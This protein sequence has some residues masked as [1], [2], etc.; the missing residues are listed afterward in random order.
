L[1]GTSGKRIERAA[2]YVS[3]DGN[4][5]WSG[6]R[7]GPNRARKDGPFATLK[8]AR[9]EIRAMG[10]LPEGGVTVYLLGGTHIM[11]ASLELTKED[12]GTKQAPILYRPWR[13][14][15][16]R[17]LGGRV[18]SGFKRVKDR[19]ILRRLGARA[20]RHV[21]E[22][23]LERCGVKDLGRFRSRGFGRDTLPAHLELFFGARRM[24][25]ARWPNDGFVRI[26]GPAEALPEG[27]GHGGPLGR[28][29]AG[30]IYKGDRPRR[31]RSLEDVWVHGYWAW[32]WADT[33]EQVESFDQATGHLKTRPPHGIY[34]IKAGQRFYFLNVLEELDRPG[35]Y[36]VDRKSGTLY[37]WPPSPIAS[38]EAAASVLEDPI[39]RVNG[40]SSI[41]LQGLRIEYGRGNGIEVNDCTDVQLVGCTIRNLGNFGAVVAGGRDNQVVGCNIYHTGD[42]GISISG[43]DRRTLAPSGHVVENNH[44]HHMGQ[45]SRCYRPGILMNGVGVRVAHNLIHDGPHSAIHFGGN[46]HVIEYNHIH[47]VC[48][49][50]GDVGALYIGRDWTQRGNIIRHNFFHHT[51]GYGMGSMA[52]YLDD[53]ASGMTVYG[54]VF[55]RC[56]RAAFIG[57]GR[58]NRVENNI[59]VD[60]DPAVMIDGRGLDPSP[61]WHNMVYKT[62]KGL[63]D[64]VD[65]RKPPY[66][67]RYPELAQL[68]PYY[69]DDKGVP[70]EGNVVIRNICVGGKW[71]VIHWR[72]DPK[73]V[74]V[75]DNLV[76]EDPCFLDPNA[77]D[78]QL[79][80][81]SPAYGLGFK[82]IP[83][84]KMGLYK[85]R[86]RP[87]LTRDEQWPR[88][89]G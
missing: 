43:G 26:D 30:F 82:R 84:E 1:K 3:T 80:D 73:L 67:V 37:F 86:N 83:M 75:Q 51:Q 23:D 78:F 17:L 46:E 24:E 52:V 8:R 59:F 68:D 74:L 10:S 20:R 31:W 79:A 12:G 22:L 60:C 40:A 11:H 48:Q 54:N 49:E 42:G 71:T 62:M 47:H 21:F 32:D 25:V 72:A 64:A 4:D 13:N 50:T 7:P 14:E 36:Y 27:D 18:L 61:V 53:C 28:I 35:E 41:T 57:G 19:G 69:S 76:D 38:A 6:R 87:R 88:G 33:Y 45:W 56:T 81:G 16:V 2:I 44:I 55:Y 9:D 39:V 63:L 34:G 58:D 85:D 65:H 29:E 70:P 5:A 77:M 89:P 66:S 15:K